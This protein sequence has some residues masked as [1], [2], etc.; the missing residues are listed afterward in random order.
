MRLEN[1]YPNFLSLTPEAQLAYVASYRLCRAKDLTL[2][3]TKRKAKPKSTGSKIDL[4]DEEKAVMKLLGLKP[5]DLIALRTLQ[6]DD[7]TSAEDE[8]L[9]TDETFEEGED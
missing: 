7:E 9:F 4:S 8:K 3:R 2:F 1:L 6:I 5:K